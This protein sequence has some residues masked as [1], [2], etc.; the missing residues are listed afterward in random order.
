LAEEKKGN[1]HELGTNK[2]RKNVI[3][4]FYIENNLLG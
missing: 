1:V 4:D 2:T 3:D